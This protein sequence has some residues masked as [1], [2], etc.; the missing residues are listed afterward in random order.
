M[1]EQNISDIISYM[2]MVWGFGQE[3]GGN[4]KSESKRESNEPLFRN[5][6]ACTIRVILKIEMIQ[7]RRV[8]R[9]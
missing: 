8:N 1:F 9:W 5:V 6:C 2:Q 3:S 7:C 4:T